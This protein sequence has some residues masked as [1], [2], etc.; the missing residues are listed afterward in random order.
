MGDYLLLQWLQTRRG[1]IFCIVLLIWTA[2]ASLCRLRPSR[3]VDP[4]QDK[5]AAAIQSMDG[6]APVVTQ[7]N[8]ET[9]DK[10]AHTEREQELR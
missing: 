5:S 8:R 9:R 10:F 3:S 7:R 2:T 6:D 1:V 4:H